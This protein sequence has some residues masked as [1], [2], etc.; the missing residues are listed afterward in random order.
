MTITTPLGRP[1]SRGD[2]V[3][4][5]FPHADL[6]SA[7]PRPAVIVQADRLDTVLPQVVVAML[8]GRMFRAAHPSRVSV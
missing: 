8:T 7:K 5:L 2:T 4:V 1:L 6:R 3:L